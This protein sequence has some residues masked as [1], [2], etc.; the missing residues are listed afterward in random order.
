LNMKILM[1]LES[2]FPPDTRVENE[3]K[4]LTESGHEVHI[5]CIKTARDL[6]E[7]SFGKA[8]IH[9]ALLS[10]FLRKSSTGALI[11]PFYFHFWR[12]FVNDLFG[13]Y[14]FDA[15]H[16]HDLPLAVIGYEM[17]KKFGVK[18]ILDL[19]E[20]WPGLL[21]ISEHLQTFPGNLLFSLK[22]WTKYEKK[23]VNLADKVIVV[24]DE[25]KDR[26]ASLGVDKGRIHVV[27]NTLNLEESRF[28]ILKEVSDKI[29]FTYAGGVTYHRGLQYVLEAAALLA[30]ERFEIWIVGDGRYL[31]TLKKQ[32]S[33]LGLD[34]QIRFWGRKSQAELLDLVCESDVALIPHVKSA[35][36][37]STI[38]HKLFQ[39]MYAEKP[40]LASD[41]IPVMRIIKETRSGWVYPWSDVEQLASFMKKI[42]NNEFD[43]KDYA[44]GKSF[45][46]NKYNWDVD[47]LN[48]LMIYK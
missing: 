18:F 26:I 10:E 48:L 46:A 33:L 9:R 35:H 29:I 23:Y 43:L 36:T 8:T 41:C 27:S 38:P 14:Q 24:V 3:I 28:G 32:A 15:I 34:D 31:N 12:K 6:S 4:A 39:Y 40:V 11:F 30:G 45:V 13:F 42:I 37:D 2:N 44:Q 5:A 22:E 25:A 21:A 16:V 19:H 20:N 47:K 7:K 1:L 17:K